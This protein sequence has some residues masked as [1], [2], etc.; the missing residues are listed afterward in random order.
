MRS[1]REPDPRSVRAVTKTGYAGDADAA[2]WRKTGKMKRDEAEDSSSAGRQT[3]P[4]ASHA[5]SVSIVIYATIRD[6]RD[7][8][9]Q[10]LDPALA[11]ENIVTGAHVVRTIDIEDAAGGT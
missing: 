9:A 5:S 8:L 1:A 3:A 6:P 2:T 7:A 10:A 11:V 4:G